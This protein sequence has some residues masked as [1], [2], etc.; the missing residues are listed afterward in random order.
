MDFLRLIGGSIQLPSM[1]QDRRQQ[2]FLPKPFNQL[3]VKPRE[4]KSEHNVGGRI[5]RTNPVKMERPL[6]CSLHREAVGLMPIRQHRCD[7]RLHPE[8]SCLLLPPLKRCLQLVLLT[9]APAR[10]LRSI[11]GPTTSSTRTEQKAL[12]MSTWKPNF[13]SEEFYILEFSSNLKHQSFCLKKNVGSTLANGSNP[14]SV[15]HVR[16]I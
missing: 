2:A 6:F 1:E 7:I 4:S 12:R 10:S 8:K 16:G 3:S 15:L 5:T 13:F 9:L 11:T 14:V